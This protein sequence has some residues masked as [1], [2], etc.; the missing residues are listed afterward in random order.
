MSLTDSKCL[1][2]GFLAGFEVPWTEAGVGVLERVD[3][4][5]DGGRGRELAR[6]KEI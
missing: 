6:K 2:D 5:R 4:E 1:Q 3:L